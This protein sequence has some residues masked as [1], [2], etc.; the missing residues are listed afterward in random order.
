MVP[1]IAYRERHLFNEVQARFCCLE[2]QTFIDTI[3]LGRCV[4]LWVSFALILNQPLDAKLKALAKA[5]AANAIP[6]ATLTD[7]GLSIAPI[8]EDKRDHVTALSRRLYNLMARVRITSL[9]AEVHSWTGFLDSF[10]HYRTGETAGDK[11]ALMAA[12]L[13]DATNAGIERM[14]ES[15]RG[16]TIHQMMLMLPSSA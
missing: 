13:A 2:K 4:G 12:I 5:A 9:L 7:K 14:A 1:P 10:T 15:S 16:V 3:E 6:D 11:A 8:R